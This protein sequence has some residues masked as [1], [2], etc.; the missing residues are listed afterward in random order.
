MVRVP[1]ATPYAF[2]WDVAGSSHCIPRIDSCERVA[3]DTY[4]F[5][6]EERSTGPVSL[7]V[8]YTA[9][10]EGNGKDKIT[11]EGIGAAGDNTDVVFKPAAPPP[12]SC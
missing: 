12:R 4:R 5:I 2:L 9:H 6:Y 7:V 10:Y 11:F 3:K 1:I 8:Q